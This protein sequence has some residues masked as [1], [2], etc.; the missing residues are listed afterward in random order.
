MSVRTPLAR[1]GRLAL[2]IG[3]HRARLPALYLRPLTER[4]FSG[5]FSTNMALA[6]KPGR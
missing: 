3:R 5:G 6:R 4:R 1:A 2:G